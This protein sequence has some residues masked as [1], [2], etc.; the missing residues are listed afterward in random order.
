MSRKSWR[1]GVRAFRSAALIRRPKSK[2][3]KRRLQPSDQYALAAL[4]FEWL[5]GEVISGPAITPLEVPELPDAESDQLSETFTTALAPEPSARFINC[6][7]FVDGLTAA[8]P[9]VVGRT[10][11]C[12]RSPT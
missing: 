4:T 8:V 10:V 5:F 3:E 2:R 6:R 9:A 7:A 1:R 11:A 12:R